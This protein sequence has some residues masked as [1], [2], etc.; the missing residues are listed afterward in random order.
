M[1]LW[2]LD[3]V[4]EFIGVRLEKG[5]ATDTI[6]ERQSDAIV[7]A[8]DWYVR[9]DEKPSYNVYPIE[10]Q[11]KEERWKQFLDPLHEVAD[12]IDKRQTSWRAVRVGRFAQGSRANLL[13]H[14][15][16]S[17]LNGGTRP[18]YPLRRTDACFRM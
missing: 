5:L 7:R 8:I 13:A 12:A 9:S 11:L 6:S 1:G 15:L 2:T 17:I 3:G 16:N 18:L 10:H 4:L 14:D